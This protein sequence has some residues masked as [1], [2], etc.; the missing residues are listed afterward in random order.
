[1]QVITRQHTF[2]LEEKKSRFIAV[3]VPV[4]SPEEAMERVRELSE[5]EAT[6][7]CFA[8]RIGDR[9]R[10]FDDGEPSGTAG[11]PILAAIERRDIDRC[12]V[13]VIRYFGGIKLGVGGL[14]RAYGKCA[15]ECLR[16]APTEEHRPRAAVRVTAPFDAIGEIYPVLQTHNAAKHLETYEAQGVV[17]EL[18]LDASALDS[19]QAAMADATRGRATMETSDDSRD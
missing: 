19:F 5:P 9:Y 16:T 12:L 13:L 17:L 6:H 4:G 11:K 1:M 2:E 3:A 10:F 7:N 18:E 8:Y 14:A 15:A